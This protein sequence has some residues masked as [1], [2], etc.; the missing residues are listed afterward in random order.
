MKPDE[1]H[2]IELYV[3]TGIGETDAAVQ[4]LIEA[5]PLDMTVEHTL[6]AAGISEPVMLTLLI[7]ND[8]TIKEM[9]KQYRQIN[10]PT[11]VL[12][13]PLLEKPLV[14]APA[15]Q[16]WTPQEGADEAQPATPFVTPP[17]LITNLGDIVISWPTLERQAAEA[18]HAI[19]YELLFLLSHGV[20]H[21]IGYDD[22]SEAGYQA[23]VN[24]QQSV[25]QT[26]GQKA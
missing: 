24:I 14:N 2:E 7:T 11:D 12:S 25:L 13:F 5:L 23:M 26:L 22:M 1:L 18:G 4:K 3:D 21:L 10:K 16:L 6:Q 19:N 9:N 15:D 17:E 20:L 8:E